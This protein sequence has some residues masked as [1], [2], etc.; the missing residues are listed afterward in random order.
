MELTE[1]EKYPLEKNRV[2][3]ILQSCEE[4][5]ERATLI[6]KYKGQYK[7]DLKEWKSKFVTFETFL[8][9]GRGAMIGETGV[10][11]SKKNQPETTVVH[12]LTQPQF[13][14]FF[15]FSEDKN[16]GVPYRVWRFEVDSAIQGGLHLAEVVAEHIR[17]SLQGEA[18][19]KIIG[20]G[21]ETS[22]EQILKQL[23][24]FYGEDG[25]A[26]SD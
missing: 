10:T 16:K 22:V 2:A 21:S 26:V 23:N 15:E 17:K 6:E 14:S 12:C 24:Q 11:L 7:A 8:T 18:K 4:P 3:K 5:P 20:F 25:A 1:D 13:S 19:N 9:L